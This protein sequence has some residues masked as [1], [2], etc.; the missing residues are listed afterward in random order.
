[1]DIC[2]DSTVSK[3]SR[4]PLEQLG[5]S[6]ATVS[7]L[8]LSVTEPLYPY[9]PCSSFRPDFDTW[10]M[11]KVVRCHRVFALDQTVAKNSWFN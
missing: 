10:Y 6:F 3:G 7:S 2:F 5:S 11:R 9:I 4:E 8:K 1:M